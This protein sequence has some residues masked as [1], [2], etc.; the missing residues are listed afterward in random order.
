MCVESWTAGLN[1]GAPALASGYEGAINDNIKFD[2]RPVFFSISF[3]D[4]K[5]VKLIKEET[6]REIPEKAK[7]EI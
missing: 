5:P 3:I 6:I 4:K 2:L 1:S 7:E